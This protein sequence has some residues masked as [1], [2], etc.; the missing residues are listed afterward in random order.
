MWLNKNVMAVFQKTHCSS[1]LTTGN[2][3][4]FTPQVPW[5]IKEIKRELKGSFYTMYS[6][7]YQFHSFNYACEI[8]AVCQIVK[9]NHLRRRNSY[10][11]DG[12]CSCWTWRIAL[13][14]GVERQSIMAPEMWKSKGTHLIESEKWERQKSQKT[15]DPLIAY[16]N[17]LSSPPRLHLHSL[18]TNIQNMSLCSGG[19]LYLDCNKK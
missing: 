4:I 12:F 16:H 2:G 7:K 14:C 15:R 18:G 6:C 19:I 13:G 17:G 10:L 3:C 11:A 8:S 9:R 5:K 1:V